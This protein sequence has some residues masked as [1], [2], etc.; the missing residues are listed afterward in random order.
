MPLSNDNIY[1]YNFS[2][3]SNKAWNFQL[4]FLRGS[5]DLVGTYDSEFLPPMFFDEI[6]IL[7]DFEEGLPFG[8]QKASLLNLKI[9]FG[10]LQ[11]D[12]TVLKNWILIGGQVISNEFYPNQFRILSNNGRGAS[13]V[14]YDVV[15][16]WGCQDVIPEQEYTFKFGETQTFDLKVLSIENFIFNKITDFSLMSGFMDTFNDTLYYFRFTGT[17]SFSQSVTLFADDASVFFAG[18]FKLLTPTSINNYLLDAITQIVGYKLRNWLLKDTSSSNAGVIGNTNTFLTNWAL[19]KQ[20]YDLTTQEGAGLGS[21]TDI[22][23]IG[24]ISNA[25]TTLGGLSIDKSKDGFYQFKNANDLLNSLCEQFISKLTFKYNRN[26]TLNSVRLNLNF[27]ATYDSLAGG[28]ISLGADSIAGEVKLIRGVYAI[29][30]S[31]VSYK[32]YKQNQNKNTYKV[33]GSLKQD[34]FDNKALFTNN[35]QIGDLADWAGAQR[36]FLPAVQIN[37]LYYIREDGF[38]WLT[39]ANCSVM[40]GTETIKTIYNESITGDTIDPADNKSSGN[41]EINR[42]KLIEWANVRYNKSG[43]NYVQSKAY[44][45]IMNDK[46]MLLECEV[47]DYLI[48]PRDVGEKIVSD[49]S[50]ILNLPSEWFFSTNHVLTSCEIDLLTGISKIKLFI[51][52]E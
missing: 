45:S 24:S 48:K 26:D 31:T 46:A 16:F 40:L 29:A 37:Q 33:Y 36:Y 47:L 22:K 34:S 11:G 52:G 39:H 25:T 44:A 17:N 51:R 6:S 23:M 21:N 5:D 41:K 49:L 9:D 27:K 13:D 8:K 15:E 38:L 14:T 12:F 28:S 1:R 19:K 3:R 2:S 10:V 4:E 18:N 32:A 50:T 30:E 20:L 43:L 35:L 42:A 7:S